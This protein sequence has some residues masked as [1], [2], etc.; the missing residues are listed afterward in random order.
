MAGAIFGALSCFAR[1]DYNLPLYAFLYIMWDQEVEEKVK[2]L[3]LLIVTW[4]VD[5]IWMVYWI[6][7]WNSDE[8]KDWQKGL[9]NFVI[10]ISVINFLM[11]IAIIFMVG[12]SQRDNIRKQMAKLQS[13]RMGQRA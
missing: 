3:I 9:H 8:M 1:A 13:A 5:F 12:F 6:P 11:K 2:L 7:H 10:F 4:L